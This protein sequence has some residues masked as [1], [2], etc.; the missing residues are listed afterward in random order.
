MTSLTK[1]PEPQTKKCFFHCK[2]EDIPN[3]LSI[4]TAL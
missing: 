2:L 1:N 3:L 4:W